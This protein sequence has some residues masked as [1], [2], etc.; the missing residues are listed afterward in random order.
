M[1]VYSFG[2]LG[3]VAII[4]LPVYIVE[5]KIPKR[6]IPIQYSI[7]ICPSR[8]SLQSFPCPVAPSLQTQPT[9]SEASSPNQIKVRK[10][11]LQ[12]QDAANC[13]SLNI[14]RMTFGWTMKKKRKK[15]KGLEG[16]NLDMKSLQESVIFQNALSPSWNCAREEHWKN[17]AT[18]T[19][20][21]E[22]KVNIAR[23]IWLHFSVEMQMTK[24]KC[25]FW[26]FD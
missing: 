24:Q 12:K 19:R 17:V 13:V 20:P 14:P 23:S 3:H 6:Q 15:K 9:V 25:V 4:S 16:E 1:Q 8:P 18:P 11:S 5:N 10:C 7:L 21:Q 2:L 26:E 22:R